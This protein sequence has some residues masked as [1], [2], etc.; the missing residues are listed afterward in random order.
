VSLQ[1][2]MPPSPLSDLKLAR[3]E[4]S[5]SSVCLCHGRFLENKRVNLASVSSHGPLGHLGRA[6]AARPAAVARRVAGLREWESRSPRR[7]RDHRRDEP[8]PPG[9]RAG[10]SESEWHLDHH[11]DR[12][13]IRHGDRLTITVR[14]VGH[15][16][17]R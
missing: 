9:S 3:S 17:S 10:R 5:L 16:R 7:P 2:S 6:A 8:E 15:R 14:R 13:D 1:E 4:H 12:D 11:G